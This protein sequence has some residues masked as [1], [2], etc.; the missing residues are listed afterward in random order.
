MILDTSGH[1]F[2]AYTKFQID[3][4]KHVEK[5]PEN[6]DGR[7]DGHL[8]SILRLFFIWAYKKLVSHIQAI[9]CKHINNYVRL[10]KK[11]FQPLV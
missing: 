9:D 8:H 3:I 2:N 11:K 4:W 1:F 5:S 7:T 10:S 6:A